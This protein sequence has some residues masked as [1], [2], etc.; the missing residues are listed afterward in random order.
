ML[1]YCKSVSVCNSVTA[2]TA[3]QNEVIIFF[4]LRFFTIRSDGISYDTSGKLSQPEPFQQ[5][6]NKY[7][8]GI[9]YVEEPL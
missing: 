2:V 7:V 1:L 5:R 8:C 4:S 9:E 6:N 3:A